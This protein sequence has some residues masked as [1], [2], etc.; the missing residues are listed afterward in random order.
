[1]EQI[2]EMLA[3][4]SF[5]KSEKITCPQKCPQAIKVGPVSSVSPYSEGGVSHSRAAGQ[6]Q[7]K[8]KMPASTLKGT[9]LRQKTGSC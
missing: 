7:A 9:L 4:T 8:E 6:K 2:G 1:M 3:V 5:V